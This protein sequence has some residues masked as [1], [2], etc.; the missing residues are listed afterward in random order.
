[1]FGDVRRLCA[2]IRWSENVDNSGWDDG[3]RIRSRIIF[4]QMRHC[5]ADLRVHFGD[6]LTLAF[7]AA[8]RLF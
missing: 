2:L 4:R 7:S 3:F 5:R 1:M 6:M 8:Y